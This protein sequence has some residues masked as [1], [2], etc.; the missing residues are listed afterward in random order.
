MSVSVLRPPKMLTFPPSSLTF[1]ETSEPIY[2]NFSLWVSM[3]LQRIKR[4][5]DDKD[6]ITASTIGSG[7]LLYWETT[8]WLENVLMMIARWSALEKEIESLPALGSRSAVLSCESVPWF[9]FRAKQVGGKVFQGFSCRKT[10]VTTRSTDIIENKTKP[11]KAYNTWK[12]PLL[13][14][15]HEKI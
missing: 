2:C 11:R 14:C 15:V 13:L 1:S 4:E 10:T 3:Y 8:L 5:K 7:S 9:P 12:I 6:L